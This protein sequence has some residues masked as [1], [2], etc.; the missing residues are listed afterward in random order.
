MTKNGYQ[1]IRTEGFASLTYRFPVSVYP[2]MKAAEV[3]HIDVWYD[4]KTKQWIIQ[5]KDANDCQV[6]AA[7]YAYARDEA[8]QIVS[9]MV[10][11]LL[12]KARAP[13]PLSE[14]I[15]DFYEPNHTHDTA[16]N[17]GICRTCG[18]DLAGEALGV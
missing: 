4:V 6:G 9:T 14:L 11:L 7:D 16:S 3:Q 2:E 1:V 12:A 18:H 10:R 13:K 15:P 8:D 17:G 5:Q